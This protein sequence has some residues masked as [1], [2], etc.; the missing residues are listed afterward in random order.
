MMNGRKSAMLKT[1]ALSLALLAAVGVVKPATAAGA[2]DFS[3]TTIDGKP[4]R[5]ADFRDKAIMVVNTAS[6][7]GFTPQY[8]QLQALWETYRDRGLVL[9]GVPA[10][11]FG[12]QEPGSAKEI[13]D[14]C[15]VNYSVTF[16]LTEKVVVTGDDAH[17]FY[18]WA[19]DELGMAAKPRWNFHKYLINANGQLVDW[20]SSITEPSAA[21]VARAIEA[22]LP[23]R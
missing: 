15:E 10:N 3:F 12:Q 9:I 4:M 14:F 11:D 2:Y 22:A 20:F 7:C 17:P 8:K 1:A 19:A 13:K 23:P 6:F 16:P 5:L 21:R 18:R